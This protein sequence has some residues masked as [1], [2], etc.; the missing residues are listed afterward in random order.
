MPP[1]K[2]LR[3]L[4][5]RSDETRGE[6]FEADRSERCALGFRCRRWQKWS[7]A[8]MTLRILHLN[9]RDS[10][11]EGGVEVLGG[12]DRVSARRSDAVRRVVA[13][14]GTR[15]VRGSRSRRSVRGGGRRSTNRTGKSSNSDGS[16]LQKSAIE[17]C[18][19]SSRSLS[20]TFVAT[21]SSTSPRAV[22]SLLMLR[23]APSV[24]TWNPASSYISYITPLLLRTK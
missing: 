14:A 17:A 2:L 7:R 16:S 13:G 4:W 8:G 24:S 6:G 3:L 22:S 1:L 18:P 23:V 19:V 20:G 15:G 5:R 12:G 11:P 10:A 21:I 9:S